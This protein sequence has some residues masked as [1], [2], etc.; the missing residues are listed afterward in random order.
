MNEVQPIRSQKKILAI[1]SYIKGPEY[2]STFRAR[3]YLLFTMG[4]NCALR[5]ND[6]LSLKTKDV[7]T[8]E[9][10]IKKYIHI[11]TK[12]A[13][14]TLQIKI[15]ESIKKALDYYLE[16]TKALDPDDYL[17]KSQT[18]QRL[19]RVRAWGLI[20]DWTGAVGLN[21]ELYGTHT[22]RKTW[23]HMAVVHFNVPVRT[24]SKKLGH[25]SIQST[26]DYIGITQKE[27]NDAEDLVC[28]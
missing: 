2:N 25:K 28:L 3:D 23:G 13:K 1:K 24:V 12:K 26:M 8:K 11:Q 10:N 5:I 20:K 16:H 14:V 21:D 17:F 7:L 22:L 4:I 9:G 15:N 6:L 18:G 19:D 27:V